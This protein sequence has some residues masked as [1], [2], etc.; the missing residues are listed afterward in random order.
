MMKAAFA[1]RHD[2]L[3]VISVKR[4]ATVDQVYATAP[5]CIDL[6][7]EC[8][9]KMRHAARC[10]SQEAG[11]HMSRIEGVTL[12]ALVVAVLTVVVIMT[13]LCG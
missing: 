3:L 4:T 13:V 6:P 8:A 7:A 10:Y 5:T 2:M 1:T 9:D 12:A 11:C